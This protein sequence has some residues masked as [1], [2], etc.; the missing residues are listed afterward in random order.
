M[1]PRSLSLLIPSSVT[2]DASDLR[3]KTL[4]IGQIARAAS[5][6][7]VDRIV[8]YRD[9]D[10]DDSGMIERILVYAETPQY[11]RKHLVPIS[12]DL[13]YA[14]TIPP[15]RTPHHPASAK[16]A[17]VGDTRVGAVVRSSD[18]GSW[19]DVGYEQLAFLGASLKRGERVNVRITSEKPVKAALVSRDEIAEY[20]GYSVT[21]SKSL[22]ES[23]VHPAS[24]VGEVSEVSEVGREELR[25]ATS[26]NGRPIDTDLLTEI[27]SKCEAR[28]VMIAMGA[29]HKGIFEIMNEEND[30]RTE[31]D[32]VLNFI[33]DQGTGTVRVEEAVTST[34]A[35]L[36]V[37]FTEPH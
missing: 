23:L 32:Y 6:F 10:L 35:I 22:E 25:I 3:S 30:Q 7:R 37:C 19:V 26:R 28:D 12:D 4:K 5:V 15:L 8:I 29:P 2:I 24:K 31:F 13:R 14:G 18:A 16:K 20:W 1:K 21:R 11:L 33:P 27:K 34:L 36:N 9:P 17:E